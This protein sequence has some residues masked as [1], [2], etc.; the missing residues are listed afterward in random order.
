MRA[1]A[2]KG[3]GAGRIVVENGPRTGPL[4]G[5]LVRW[6]ICALLGLGTLFN[7]ALLV[8]EE[9]V[10][11]R[12]DLQIRDRQV[13][14]GRTTVV[15]SQGAMVELHWYS[16]EAVRLHIHGYN[17]AQL[18]VA[19]TPVVTRFHAFAT[20]RFPVTSH[21]FGDPSTGMENH[22]G[23]RTLFYLEVHP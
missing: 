9:T 15:V 14:G 22:G 20:G 18:V 23:H 11:A 10:V 1:A 17:I 2:V 6:L 4:S 7:A 19:D 12:I 5:W 3:D 16:D 13:Q 21:G 8:A